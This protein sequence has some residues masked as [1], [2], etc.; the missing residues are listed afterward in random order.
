MITH[1]LLKHHPTPCYSRFLRGPTCLHLLLHTMAKSETDDE[2]RLRE[3]Q[4]TLTAASIFVHLENEDRNIR[5][6]TRRSEHWIDDNFR[7]NLAMETSFQFHGSAH[8][9][10]SLEFHSIFS[11]QRQFSIAHCVIQ[12]TIELGH[13]PSQCHILVY[14]I[15]HHPK[16]H[17]ILLQ[18]SRCLASTAKLLW[19]VFLIFE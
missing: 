8:W 1:T 10:W 13:T 4:E 2:K 5:P 15:K 11:W 3:H 9:I 18:P 7:L 12:Q 17:S 14:T 6:R 16:V 19:D